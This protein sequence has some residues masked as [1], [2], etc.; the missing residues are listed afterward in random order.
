MD[1]LG[2]ELLL[3]FGPPFGDGL[4][5]SPLESGSNLNPSI[6]TPKIDAQLGT[7]IGPKDGRHRC[8]PQSL[9]KHHLTRELIRQAS[10]RTRLG[11]RHR[12]RGLRQSIRFSNQR[13]QHRHSH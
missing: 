1:A 12:L 3:Q 13:I 10:D 5:I 8:C 2:A 4:S 11:K 6:A 9:Q 7:G